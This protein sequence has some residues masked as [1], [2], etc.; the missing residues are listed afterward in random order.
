V[1]SKNQ[2]TLLIVTVVTTLF[3]TGCQPPKPSAMSNDQVVQ[4]V[5][6]ILKA[7]DAGDFQSFKQDFSDEMKNAFTEAQFTNLAAL[8][9]NASGNYVSYAD[10]Q[11]ELSNSQGYAVYRLTCKYSLESVIVTVT[12]KVDGEK[13]EGLFFDSTNLRKANKEERHHLRVSRGT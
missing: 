7:I 12:F 9:K 11:P 2:I 5:G 6:N 13:V 4:V 10:S 1:K 8:L 3:L